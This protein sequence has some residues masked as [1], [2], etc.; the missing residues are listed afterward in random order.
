M[1]HHL[2]CPA[3]GKDLLMRTHNSYDATD[4]MDSRLAGSGPRS[5]SAHPMISSNRSRQHRRLVPSPQK[6]TSRNRMAELVAD[7]DG[8]PI[9]FRFLLKQV[10][11]ETQSDTVAKDAYTHS[12]LSSTLENIVDQLR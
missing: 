10:P 1:A 4:R 6:P 5:A 12:L 9:L 7:I 11:A 3:G 2:G 8:L